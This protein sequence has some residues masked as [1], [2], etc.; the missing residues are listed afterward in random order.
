[1]S[2]DL[3]WPSYKK[4]RGSCIKKYQGVIRIPFS[5]FLSLLL[6]Y[7]SLFF[8]WASQVTEIY[9]DTYFLLPENGIMK[10]F[11]VCLDYVCCVLQ[12]I[13]YSWTC[14]WWNS[15]SSHRVYW[16]VSVNIDDFYANVVFDAN[17][18]SHNPWLLFLIRCKITA[19][20]GMATWSCN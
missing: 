14:S 15:S 18:E 12:A 10:V 1:M 6:R 3:S 17:S 9:L 4:S 19:E 7:Y 8:Y 13:S 16:F 20:D 11:L 2:G 5:N